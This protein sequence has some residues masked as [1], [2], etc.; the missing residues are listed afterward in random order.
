MLTLTR[1][2]VLGRL[3]VPFH[4]L[5]YLAEDREVNVGKLVDVQAGRAVRK[6]SLRKRLDVAIQSTTAHER[7][8]A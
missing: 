1:R 5:D 4:L 3:G 2:T 6:R 7:Y 8:E